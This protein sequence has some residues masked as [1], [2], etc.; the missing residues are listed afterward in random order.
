MFRRLPSALLIVLALLVCFGTA[1]SAVRR[2][3]SAGAAPDFPRTAAAAIAHGKRDEAA[4]LA[5]ARGA[6]DAAAAVVLAQLAIARGKYTDAQALL[7]PAAGREPAGEAALELALL[8]RGIGRAGDAQP[9]LMNVFRAG[10]TSS[11]PYVLF[12]AGRAAH[13]LNR[14][15][16]AN[17]FYREAER[18]GANKAM[19]E[20]AWGRLFQEKYNSPEALKSFETALEADPQWA[21]AHAGLAR[22]LENEDPPKAAAAAAKAL[23]IDPD[24]A[25]ARL[26]LAGLHL[27]DDRDKEARAEIDKVL[28]FNPSHLDAHAML[29]AVAYVKDDK[30]T[31]DAEVAKVLAINPAY[32][33]VYRLAGQHAASHYRFDEAAALAEK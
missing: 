32:G 13:A 14:P 16:D 25:D 10:Q 17:T 30:A 33:E 21:P 6:N 5:A 12:R 1:G 24:L 28:A 7:E 15:R 20:T 18:A 26:L 23:A 3:Q 19:V 22:V 11:D 4:R 2:S 31:Y 27:D 8:L 9:L 29:A